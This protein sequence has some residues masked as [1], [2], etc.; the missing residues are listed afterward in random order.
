MP[1]GTTVEQV[2][3]SLAAPPAPNSAPVDWIRQG[4]I[5]AKL[6]MTALLL[7]YLASWIHD[8]QRI[9]GLEAEPTP[10]FKVI[11]KSEAWQRIYSR[12]VDSTIAHTRL[13][14]MAALK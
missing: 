5:L 2:E 6:A 4:W 11:T 12:A 14:S 7:W 10:P 13:E 8:F 9:Q 1:V 3:F